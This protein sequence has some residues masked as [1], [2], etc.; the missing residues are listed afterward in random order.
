MLA[1]AIEQ[2]VDVPAG[3]SVTVDKPLSLSGRGLVLARVSALIDGKV[4][5]SSDQPLTALAFPKAA[6][7]PDPRERFG[8]SF[9][10]RHLA[11]AG[12]AIG[13][14]WTRWYPCMSWGEVQKKGADDWQ[15]PDELLNDLW[16]KGISATLVLHDIPKWAEGKAKN[17]P[18]DMEDWGAEDPRWKGL[19]VIT[20]WDRWVNA[21]VTRYAGKPVV[22]E[23]ANEPDL[24]GSWDAGIYA[25]MAKR[26]HA[27]V[28]KA[29]PHAEL[30]A[31]VTWP[32]VSGWTRG[33]VERGGLAAFDGHSFHNYSPGELAGADS[34]GDL[35]KLFRSYGDGKK[36]IWFNEGW[37][38]PPPAWTTPRPASPTCARP[39][40][41][42]T[43][44]EAPPTCSRP[45]WRSSSPSTSATA[46][47]ARAGGTG[48]ARA[49]SGGTTTGT[50]RW[51][52]APT[53]C[54]ATSSAAAIPCAASAR[55]VR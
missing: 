23:F 15:W 31:N 47:M 46:R 21:A 52:W 51:R 10:S 14:G 33:F 22:W 1:P 16:N 18:K 13:L 8:A 11:A 35:R 36:S 5:E 32:G 41:R 4:V 7:R 50:R 24:H 48:S 9:R 38:S 26:T 30:L 17:L 34:I 43:P 20:S 25:A 39:R 44:C 27:M 55:M 12:Q 40:W 54:F 53:T 2:A 3:G 42:T 28:K 37:T 49:P 6:T 45:G 19:A 29:D